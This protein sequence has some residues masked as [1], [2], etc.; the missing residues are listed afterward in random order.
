[1]TA[2]TT[3]YIRAFRFQRGDDFT[4]SDPALI[5]A[6]GALVR[7]AKQRRAAAMP[8]RGVEYFT[9]ADDVYVRTRAFS[10]GILVS[11]DFI[12][13]L[14]TE[15]TDQDLVQVTSFA[16]RLH[17]GTDARYW[18]GAAWAI[19]G[20][21]DWNT[22]ADFNGNL[23]SYAGASIAI[24]VR[25][26][27]TDELITPILSAV[28]IRWTG[29]VIDNY[30]EWI[31]R[32]VVRS[33]K[34]NIRPITDFDVPGDGTAAIDLNAF[35][36]DAAF[37]L[38]DVLAVYDHTADPA[39]AVNLLDTYVAGI[40][41]LT[42][43][44]PAGNNAWL[45]ATYA[46]DVAVTT[47]TDFVTDAQVPALW[48]TA[49]TSPRK[50]RGLGGTGP[51]IINRATSP[52]SGT[53]FPL[54]VSLVD[55]DF[56]LAVIAPTALDLTRLTEAFQGWMKTHPTLL[57]SAFDEEVTLMKG[58]AFDWATSNTDTDDTRVDTNFFSLVNVPIY[59]DPNAVNAAGDG[60]QA[61]P[62]NN[63]SGVER[64]NMGFRRP[65]AAGDETVTIQE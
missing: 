56:T 11:F 55:L 20:A 47:N 38:V 9:T 50:E 23:A 44:I 40:V 58:A 22:L 64:V 46:P 52:P 24:E 19:A 2:R 7:L 65:N 30:R 54:P 15:P 21:G 13:A 42:A 51:A 60:A 43:P 25:L 6:Q 8:G 14:G 63:V 32:T 49:I 33:L 57:S 10:P 5:T 31:Y 35:D 16:Y 4:L 27:T 28:C 26:K 41:T 1:M 45:E 37:N 53:A 12:E 3:Q 18:D 29:R 39:H 59:Y 36:F 48:I 61:G 34:N 62:D 17:D